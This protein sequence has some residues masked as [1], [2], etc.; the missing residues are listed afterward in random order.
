MC[1]RK[2][3]LAGHLF[4]D[5]QPGYICLDGARCDWCGGYLRD[6]YYGDLTTY[7]GKYHI[8]GVFCSPR[9]ESQASSDLYSGDAYLVYGYSSGGCFITTAVCSTLDKGDDCAELTSFR[10]FRDGWLT[11]DA[12]GQ[13]LIEEYYQIAPQI[14]R[15]IDAETTSSDIYAGIWEEYLTPALTALQA[16][17]NQT[18]KDIYVDMVRDL[19]ETY[20]AQLIL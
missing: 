3:T 8:Q 20:L 6:W 1:D 10:Q 7:S 12:G 13:A 14:V 4:N 9:C 5:G 19:Q 2:G 17:D 15:A 11:N 16:A 18:A